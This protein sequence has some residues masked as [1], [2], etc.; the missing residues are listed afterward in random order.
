MKLFILLLSITLSASLFARESSTITAENDKSDLQILDLVVGIKRTYSQT[1]Q[2]DAKVVELLG[3]DGMNP[4]RMVL[5]LSTGYQDTKIYELGIMM[6]EA[7]RI[8]FL[9]KDVVVINYTQDSFKD[10]DS[11]TP[12]QV[13]KS[14]TIQVLRNAD[15]TLANEV[16]ILK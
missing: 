4:T 7:R 6:Y 16:K 12:I 15:G 8:V 2:L 5:I 11:M 13:N 3:G 14:I 10:D 1:S 9:D